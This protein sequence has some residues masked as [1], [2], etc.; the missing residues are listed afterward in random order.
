[1]LSGSRTPLGL[2]RV[3]QQEAAGT[4]ACVPMARLRWA[5]QGPRVEQAGWGPF[6]VNRT[7]CP[8]CCELVTT[9][10]LDEGLVGDPYSVNRTAWTFFPSCTA[11]GYVL[12][13]VLV[14]RFESNR[15]TVCP[16]VRVELVGLVGDPTR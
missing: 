7:A 11:Q 1:M 14:G 2:V 6:T 5:L 16:F 10:R 15:R 3:V 8:S 13:D 12:T 4:R 9:G